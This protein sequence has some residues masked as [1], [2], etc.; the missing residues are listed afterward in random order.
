MKKAGSYSDK[1]ISPEGFL[2][3]IRPGNRIFLSSEPAS[4]LCVID[5]LISSN[6]MNVMD[7]ELVQLM[8]M[9][10]FLSPDSCDLL[11]FRLKT[12]HIGESLSREICYGTFDYIGRHSTFPVFFARNVLDIDVKIHEV[13]PP[14]EG[15][16]NRRRW[17]SSHASGP[18][19][20]LRSES[21]HA[22]Y[23][24]RRPHIRG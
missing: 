8:T 1:V 4:P 16:M 22:V 15:R 19:S 20:W 2:D 17:A 13:S 11:H 5:A 6:K 18:G 3:T 23:R 12:F 7:L 10:S 14:D 24:D 21:E 9:G